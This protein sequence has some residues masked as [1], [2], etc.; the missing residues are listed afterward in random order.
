VVVGLIVVVE[1]LVVV[2]ESR[3]KRTVRQ[4]FLFF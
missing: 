3:G 4:N 2:A 1:L